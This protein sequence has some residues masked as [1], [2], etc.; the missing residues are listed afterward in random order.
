MSDY[1]QLLSAGLARAMGHTPKPRAR[2]LQAQVG[3]FH[4][5]I[6]DGAK[7]LTVYIYDEIELV[8]EKLT[9]AQISELIIL[10][11]EAQ[12]ILT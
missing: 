1:K 4:L 11:D 8:K 6:E 10:L 9:L 5:E 7:E 2:T 3:R 12:N